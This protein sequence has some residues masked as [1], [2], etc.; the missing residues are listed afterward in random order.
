MHDMQRIMV[1]DRI[2]AYV[3]DIDPAQVLS[4]KVTEEVNGEHSLT[5]T[6]LQELDQT[7]RVLL[8]DGMG[9]WHEYVVLGIKSERPQ[10]EAVAREYYCVWSIQY[11]LSATYINDQFGCGVVPGHTSV[12][13]TPRRAL[14]CALAGTS[15]WQIGTIT[16]T[17]QAAA[18]FYRRSG[19]EGLQ[20]VIERWGGELQ[21]TIEVSLGGVTARRVD[22]LEHVGRSDAT[23]RFD[24][25]HD[26]AKIKQTV[27]DEV[28]P[29][30]IVPLG[31]SVET[32]AGGYTRRPGI[33]SVNDGVE[34]LQDDDVAPLVRVP[35]GDGGWEYPT[36]IVKND[37]YELPADLKAWAVAHISEY[38]RPRVTY[39][40]N[41]AQFAQAGLD[42][43]GVAL[44]DEVV[45]VDRTFCEGGLRITA[46]VVKIKRDLL[47]PSSMELTIGNAQTTLAGQLSAIAGDVTALGD[48]TASASDYQ[49]SA[50]YMAALV[51][52]LNDEINASGGY[53]YMVPGI[54]TRT[55]DVPVSDPAVGSEASRVVE[56]RG[57]TIR[58]ADSRTSSGDW[59][60]TNVFTADGINSELV[61][62]VQIEA[63]YIG[64]LAGSGNYWDL[65]TGEVR[66]ASTAN[67]GGKTVQQIID[68]V[69]ATISAVDVQYAQ[70]QSATT[71]PTS[72]WSTTAPA[73]REGYY[74]WQ[75]T[76]T[77]TPEGT[78]YSTPVMISGRDGTNGT[79]VTIKGS[80]NTYADLIAAHPTGSDG[81]AYM[82]GTDLYV[83]NGSAWEDVGQIQGP[84]GTNGTNGTDGSQIWTATANPTTPNYTF[85][86]ADLTGPSGVTP[87]VGDIVVRSYYRYTITSVD[88]TTVLAG[89]RTSI[90]G[91]PG[92]DGKSV[93][94]QSVTKVD[95]VTTVVLSDG[96]TQSTLT[97]DDGGDGPR[98]LPGTDGTNS[99]VHI[100]WANSA[101]GT[102]D[103]STTVS[104]G[105]SY[106]GVYSDEQEDDSANPADYSWSRI[107]GQPG[108]PGAD[109]VG[110]TSIVE[111]YYLSTSS[112]TQSGGSW[113]TTPPAYVAGRYYWTRSVITWDDGTTTITSAVLSRGLNSANSTAAQAKSTAESAQSDV[114]ALS[115][116]DAIF[117]LLTDNGAIQG[118]YMQDGQL[119]VNASYMKSGLIASRDSMTYW[120]LDNKEFVFSF[121]LTPAFSVDSITINRRYTHSS[122]WTFR[123]N[124]SYLIAFT[125]TVRPDLPNLDVAL[126]Q[127]VATS[128]GYVACS[129]RRMPTLVAQ[130]GSTRRYT[131]TV[132]TIN[133]GTNYNCRLSFLY[134]SSTSYTDDA[135]PYD[136][137]DVRVYLMPNGGD[138]VE[139]FETSSDADTIT[140]LLRAG[141]VQVGHN[142]SVSKLTSGVLDLSDTDRDTIVRMAPGRDMFYD[143]AAKAMRFGSTGTLTPQPTLSLDTATTPNLLPGMLDTAGMVYYTASGSE[144]AAGYNSTTIS[145]VYGVRW[146]PVVMLHAVMTLSA[147]S[148]SSS[149]RAERTV[150]KL[151]KEWM[152]NVRT[153]VATGLLGGT[154]SGVPVTFRISNN[155]DRLIAVNGDPSYTAAIPA[156]TTLVMDATYMLALS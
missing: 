131:A 61:R 66:M 150:L 90:R 14:E 98:G 30:R 101:D 129:D 118:L 71:S 11:D 144:V 69:D 91:A 114:D 107:E 19:W 110:I 68:G 59:N 32:E 153:F 22:L 133:P 85:T 17:T 95:G 73:W 132:T 64:N 35:D 13:Q 6:T 45:C 81:D 108:Q 137:T 117:N 60:W 141:T 135:W 38:T 155:Y 112:S 128:T 124:R 25:G 34:W 83:W 20:T 40:A 3:C 76:A 48:E 18:S 87:R 78:D 123:P 37:T 104:A 50:A 31:K 100:A 33:E 127:Y 93:F 156:G 55:Y 12:P 149:G 41:V 15:R 65:D 106:L 8:Q 42:P 39:E 96:T 146:G 126:T 148:A 109:G 151:T 143:S 134:P 142:G 67:L 5:L 21:A 152:A 97:I 154:S 24:Y 147:F 79:S 77:T 1:F 103:F 63:G 52:R 119:Y 82:V 89:T 138:G 44:G 84:P 80:Y 139:Q 70:N 36:S 105:K 57:G 4:A 75:R 120:D 56:I 125:T 51:G 62:A 115:T 58:I 10:G 23:R 72:G 86:I 116:Q 27:H 92:A 145:S 88:T 47:D 26:L 111:Q 29:C 16:V 113:V 49:A 130:S 102:A 28:W 43:H 9:T 121:E 122:T 54:G 46:R 94:V 2:D 140:T 53:W 136:V 74:I 99:Y 7:D